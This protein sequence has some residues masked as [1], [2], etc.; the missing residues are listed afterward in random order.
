M[1][2]KIDQF[3]SVWAYLAG[4]GTF[5]DFTSDSVDGDPP[6]ERA[7]FKKKK[8]DVNGIGISRLEA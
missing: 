5:M 4:K 7:T 6:P 2:N 1:E 8:R 3:S